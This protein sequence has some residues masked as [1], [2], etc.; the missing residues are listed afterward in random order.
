M[1]LLISMRL[2]F[3]LSIYHNL[4]SCSSLSTQPACK[5]FESSALLQFKQSFKINVSASFDPFAYPKI[6][7]WNSRERND[8]CS[9]D[10]VLCDRGTGYVI[11]LDL[12]SSQLY[13]SFNSSSSLFHLVYLQKLNLADNDFNYSQIP[14]SI[15]QPLFVCLQWSNSTR[16]LWALQ[17]GFP[18]SLFQSIET[19]KSRP[20]KCCWELNQPQTSL[21]E[22]GEHIFPGTS[23]LGQLVFFKISWPKRLWTVRWISHGDFQ[24]TKSSIPQCGRQWKSHRI[25]TR[26]PQ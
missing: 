6:S 21:F 1:C 18:W 16:N 5:D 14:P 20:K 19:S 4:K 12:S 10:G 25:S 11:G 22:Y 8:C 7:S 15:S 24:V 2:L 3:F 17:L 23:H 9:W 13:G 26:I